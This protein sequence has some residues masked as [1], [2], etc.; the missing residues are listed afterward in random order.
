MSKSLVI[1][2]FAAVRPPVA[3]AT[4]K[5]GL[6]TEEQ[7]AAAIKANELTLFPGP[8]LNPADYADDIRA[9]QAQLQFLADHGQNDR[10]IGLEDCNIAVYGATSDGQNPDWKDPGAYIFVQSQ[11][12]GKAVDFDLQ[13]P[14]G[15][16]SQAYATAVAIVQLCTPEE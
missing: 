1:D 7:L 11:A 6:L 14:T 15:F 4:R 2:G 12:T 3:D 16:P 13:P 10:L 8:M 5:P 9:I